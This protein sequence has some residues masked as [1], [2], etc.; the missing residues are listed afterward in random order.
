MS[1]LKNSNVATFDKSAI[2]D[3]DFIRAKY[4]T[5]PLPQNGI[6]SRVTDSEILVLYISHGRNASNYF[7]IDVSE[8]VDGKWDIAFSS[9]LVNV[10]SESKV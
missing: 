7:R 2:K 3:G 8:V 4:H 10:S 1:I 9:D 6:V 5:W